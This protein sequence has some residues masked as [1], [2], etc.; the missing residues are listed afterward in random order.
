MEKT[1][2]EIFAV[3][4]IQGRDHWQRIGTAFRNADGSENLK[5]NLLPTDPKATIQVRDR[6]PKPSDTADSDTQ[7]ASAN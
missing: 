1:Y 2:R 5:F 4:N 7:E 3:T 6:L